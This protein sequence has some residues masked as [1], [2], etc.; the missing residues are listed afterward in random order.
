MRLCVD[1]VTSLEELRRVLGEAEGA[2]APPRL[3]AVS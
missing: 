2:W 1:G 3:T